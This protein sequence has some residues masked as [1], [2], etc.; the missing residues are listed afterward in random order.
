MSSIDV[1][2]Q[3]VVR[4]EDARMTGSV[5]TLPGDRGGRPGLASPRTSTRSAFSVRR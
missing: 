2:I 4:Q 5:P 1:A 3:F